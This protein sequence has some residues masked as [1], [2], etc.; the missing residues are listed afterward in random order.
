MSDE[1]TT[2]EEMVARYGR[3]L[4]V[5]DE[6]TGE[7]K[8]AGMAAHSVDIYVRTKMREESWL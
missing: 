6:E 8:I 4:A 2:L 1:P 3:A 5:I 7:L